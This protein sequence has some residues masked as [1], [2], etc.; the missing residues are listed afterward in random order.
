MKWIIFTY[1]NKDWEKRVIWFAKHLHQEE[2]L[3]EISELRLKG[4]TD[5]TLNN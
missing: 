1:K 3:Y 4:A 5:F 2:I